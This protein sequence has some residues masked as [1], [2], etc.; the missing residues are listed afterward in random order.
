MTR[1]RFKPTATRQ[2]RDREALIRQTIDTFLSR[3][4]AWPRHGDTMTLHV[5]PPISYV[6][7]PTETIDQAGISKV[8]RLTYTRTFEEGEGGPV[9]RITCEGITVAEHYGVRRP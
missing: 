1:H 5:S 9:A 7:D 3:G 4:G 6:F 2:R 8:E